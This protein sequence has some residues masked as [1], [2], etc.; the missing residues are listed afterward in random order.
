M[1]NIYC[2]NVPG[3][4]NKISWWLRSDFQNTAW[5]AMPGLGSIGL[6]HTLITDP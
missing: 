4:G 6:I 2:I 1:L 5:A 3:G